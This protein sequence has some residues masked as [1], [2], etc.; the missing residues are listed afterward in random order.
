MINAYSSI[1]A[2]G[3]KA[4]ENL[5]DEP[6]QVEEKIDGSQFSMAVIDGVLYCR[7]KKQNIIVEEPEPMFGLAVMV[8]R[9]LHERKLLKPSWVYRCEYLKSNHHNVLCYDRV[10]ESHLALFDICIANTENYLSYEDK[11]Y[12]AKALGISCVPLLYKGEVDSA[13]KLKSFLEY[14]SFLGG[15]KIEGFVVKNYKRFGLDKKVLMGKYVREEFKEVQGGEWRKNNPAAKDIVTKLIERYKSPARWDKAVQH[16]R[17]AGELENSPRDIGKL[18]REIP[19]DV[20][21]E[22]EEEI[23]QLLFNHYWPQIRRGIISGFP[24][25]YKENLLEKQFEKETVISVG[26]A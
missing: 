25:Y 18:I 5:F 15:Q 12:E 7:S 24:E 21:K 6:V 13:D 22:C 11:A 10:P 26:E 4:L 20:Q 16:L 3:H 17:E 2:I 23:K 19:T 8:A 14:Q 1:F 9:A